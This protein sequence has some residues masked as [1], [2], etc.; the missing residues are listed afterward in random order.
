VSDWLTPPDNIL[1]GDTQG[2][3]HDAMYLHNGDILVAE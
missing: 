3:T 1:W 2:V